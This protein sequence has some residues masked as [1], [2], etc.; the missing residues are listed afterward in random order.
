MKKFGKILLWIFGGLIVIIGLLA[1]FSPTAIHIHLEEEIDAP[2]DE[3]WAVL[4]HR[5][6]EIGEW[7]P[8]V[9]T[10]RAISLDEV[11]AG[12]TVAPSAPV[13]GRVTPNPLGD[14]TEVLTMYSEDDRTFTFEADGLPP[15]V[16]HTTSTTRVTEL[17]N[18][19]SL[20]TFDIEMGFI[21]PFNVLGPVMQSR[22]QSSAAGPAGIIK[23][24]KTY[25]ESGE[26]SQAH[27]TK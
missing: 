15:I 1:L 14:I 12:F 9:E 23:D 24:L 20:V 19:H 11:P 4:A 17:D 26:E 25:L 16:T 6:A 21:R 5:F 22:L 2:A 13:P 18:G 10:S 27:L 8:G 7:A 3:A